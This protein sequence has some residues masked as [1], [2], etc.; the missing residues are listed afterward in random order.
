MKAM[1]FFQSL[2]QYPIKHGVIP[3]PSCDMDSLVCCLA[4]SFFIY[5]KKNEI[6]HPLIPDIKLNHRFEVYH[7]L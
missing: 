4:L 1:E 7:S 5:K 2:S 3:N 6:V